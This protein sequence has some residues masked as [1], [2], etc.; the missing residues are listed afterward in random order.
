MVTWFV[1]FW[2]FS[3]ILFA[4]ISRYLFWVLW[5]SGSSGLVSR[6]FYGL[7]LNDF[8]VGVGLGFCVADFVI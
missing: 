8:G 3:D 4:A 5:V 6:M 7:D 2:G 1:L